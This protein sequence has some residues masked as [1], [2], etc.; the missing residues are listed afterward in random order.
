MEVIDLCLE[1]D[2]MV[3]CYTV[4]RGEM[5][6]TD[7]YSIMP[8]IIIEDEEEE[9][10]KEEEITCSICLSVIEKEAIGGKAPC[11]V[12]CGHV[13]HGHCIKEWYKRQKT[14]PID[15]RVIDRPRYI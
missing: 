13:Y 6:D 5:E 10:E 15:R 2:D 8:I 1:E 14:C 9:E 4:T 7:I 3:I 11:M 12:S